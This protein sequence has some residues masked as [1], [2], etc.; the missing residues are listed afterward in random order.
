MIYYMTEMYGLPI[1]QHHISD[2]V[3]ISGILENESNT[4]QAN[5]NAENVAND[6]LECIFYP[7]IAIQ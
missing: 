3:S 5:D 1:L 7:N 2:R 4:T 6:N